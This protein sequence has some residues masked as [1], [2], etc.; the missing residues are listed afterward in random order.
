MDWA[1]AFILF[2]WVTRN[3]L[4]GYRNLFL[5]LS[6]LNLIL[7]LAIFYKVN[8]DFSPPFVFSS[9]LLIGFSVEAVG[10]ATG[11]LFGSYAYSDV[12]G[13]KNF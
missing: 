6:P 10:V 13:F 12:F 9:L 3:S 7:T 8:K 4:T 5:P 1:F 11:I 2:F